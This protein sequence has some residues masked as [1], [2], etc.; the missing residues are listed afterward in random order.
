MDA[1]YKYSPKQEFQS[2]CAL[3]IGDDLP[4]QSAADD[5]A[6]NNIGVRTK[7]AFA[8][9]SELKHEFVENEGG[10]ITVSLDNTSISVG[11]MTSKKHVLTSPAHAATGTVAS[12]VDA[13]NKGRDSDRPY[14]CTECEKTYGRRDYLREH[15]MSH[16]GERPFACDLCPAAY[17]RK[18]QLTEHKRKHNSDPQP[19]PHACSVCCKSFASK[20][21]RKQHEKNHFGNKPFPCT[22][23][24]ASFSTAADRDAHVFRKHKKESSST[25]EST[26]SVNLDTFIPSESHLTSTLKQRVM[27]GERP[28]QCSECSKS[29]ASTRNLKLHMHT[30]SRD[31]LFACAFCDARFGRLSSARQH[32][33]KYH[34][35]EEDA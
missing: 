2:A 26:V 20:K 21:E 14:K 33:K 30:H 11:K 18:S 3:N 28:F 15:V 19:R 34:S 16:T 12:A 7:S 6:V 35:K 5:T 10:A 1:E 31:R 23:C 32:V 8:S 17:K 24:P 27:Q 9:N 13:V 29:F 22:S 25:D 4:T